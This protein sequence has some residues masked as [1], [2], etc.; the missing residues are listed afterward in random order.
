MKEA[1]ALDFIYFHPSSLILCP[2]SNGFDIFQQRVDA[3]G[4]LFDRVADE[5]KRRSMPQIQRKAQLLA[6]VGCGVSQRPQGDQVLFFVSLHGHVDTGVT[7]IVC[8]ADF[9]HRDQRQSR[10][11]QFV[12]HD[13]R[14]LFAQRFG[15]SLWPMHDKSVSSK[16]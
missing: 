2:F 4:F 13:L 12:T 3:L 15:N 16:R 8:Y 9:G 10:I 1:L 7:E 11:L 6:H 14:D 5:V